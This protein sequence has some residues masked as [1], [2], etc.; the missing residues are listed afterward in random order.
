MEAISFFNLLP[1]E[2]LVNIFRYLTFKNEIK[3]RVV[4]KK[5][6]KVFEYIYNKNIHHNYFHDKNIKEIDPE[7]HVMYFH[8]RI[9]Y[10]Q[11]F[12]ID[13][14]YIRSILKVNVNW[15]WFDS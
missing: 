12:T 8:Q 7:I 14:L 3:I 5:F 6:L 15:I 2:T 1:L 11:G 4:S 13:E 9:R 10:E